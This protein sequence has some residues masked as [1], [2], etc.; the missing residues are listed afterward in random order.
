[1]WSTGGTIC[2]ALMVVT[3]V[4]SCESESTPSVD[5]ESGQSADPGASSSGVSETPTEAPTVCPHPLGGQC[6]GELESGRRYRTEIF[7]P[8]IAYT[9][10]PGWSNMED[11]PG[12]FLLLPP[13]AASRVWM[14]G[15]PTIS[16]C[17]AVRRWL[18]Q[19][20][21][22]SRCLEWVLSRKPWLPRSPI[23]PD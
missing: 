9:T 19:I 22:P 12:N 18:P 15:P 14:P 5:A 11:L 21:P 2:A 1:M 6:L 23:A 4:A 13:V 10:P 20:V 17:T 7:T 3:L 8:R 16:A